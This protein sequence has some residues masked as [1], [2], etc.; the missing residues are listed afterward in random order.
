MVQILRTLK[1]SDRTK[2]SIASNVLRTNEKINASFAIYVIKDS[3]LT[4]SHCAKQASHNAFLDGLKSILTLEVYCHCK[5]CR[6][7]NMPCS[8]RLIVSNESL[9][10]VYLHSIVSLKCVNCM[11]YLLK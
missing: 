4:V 5:D 7:D 2:D 11:W 9:T 1:E 10:K 6:L 3:L 8:Q